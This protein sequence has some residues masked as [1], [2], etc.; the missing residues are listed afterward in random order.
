M[1]YITN[2]YHRKHCKEIA[3]SVFVK[4]I[5]KLGFAEESSVLI[6]VN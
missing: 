4:N 6:D 5:F 1:K 3:E 2:I